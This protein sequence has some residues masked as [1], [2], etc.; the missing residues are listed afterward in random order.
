[1]YPKDFFQTH[2][3]KTKKGQCFVLMPFMEAMNDIFET[4]REAVESHELNFTC[5]RAKD[6]TGGGYILDDILKGIEE[7]EIVIADLTTSNP[8]VFYEVGIAHTRKDKEKIIL[9]TQNIDTVPF[10]LRPFRCI[11]YRQSIGGAKELQREL[12]RA[13]IDIVKGFFR[14]SLRDGEEWKTPKMLFGKDNCLYGVRVHDS[15]IGGD[16]AKF[17]LSMTRKI[18]GEPIEQ[19]KNTGHGIG[20]GGT[21]KVPYIPWKITLESVR[22]DLAFFS[23]SQEPD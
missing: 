22:D 19:I 23:L 3:V 4:I 9:L 13:I 17:M 10:D 15:A 21:V 1:M 18:A 2:D 12:V 20:I 8:N 16:A 6:L 11:M 5:M 14:F 7:S